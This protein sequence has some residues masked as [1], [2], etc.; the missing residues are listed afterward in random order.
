MIRRSK[1]GRSAKRSFA[2]IAKKWQNARRSLLGGLRRLTDF[3]EQTIS[4]PD[5]AERKQPNSG[6]LVNPLYWL[7][8]GFKFV[9]RYLTSRSA[10][11]AVQGMPALLGIVAPL[12]FGIWLT[13]SESKLLDRARS[14]RD[15]LISQ[16]QHEEADFYARWMCTLRP[17]EPQPLLDRARLLHAMNR[18]D[19]AK[20]I[21]LQLSSDKKFVPAL[22]WLCDL[23]LQTLKDATIP[24]DAKMQ[25]LTAR[26]LFI[27]AK[28]PSS[29]QAQ[30]MLG[31]VYL[32]QNN[33]AQAAV[34]FQEVL[35]L[36]RQPIPEVHYSLA[37]VQQKLGEVAQSRKNAS[38]AAD[39][40]LER[41]ATQPFALQ[42]TVQLLRSL[43]MAERENEAAD[44]VNQLLP[45]R[46]P[47]EQEQLKWLLA[48]VYAQWSKRLRE[49]EKRTAQDL[50]R[51]VN[52]VHQGL[53]A[54]ASN[55][56]ITEE[57]V[58][59][60]CL[61]EIDDAALDQQLEI[62]LNSGVSPG[63]VHFIQGTRSL[64]GDTPDPETAMQHFELA[65]THNAALPG[66]LNN[67]AD[68]MADS[69]EADLDQALK[70]IEQAITSMPNQP[71]F[72]DTRGK[73]KLRQGEPLEAIADFEKALAAPEIRGV[74]HRQL[75]EAFKTLGNDAESRKHAKLATKYR[76]R[77]N[78]SN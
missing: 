57:L 54:S 13:P 41:L 11:A 5:G 76:N 10:L 67:M 58:A 45:K 40:F 63:L 36:T 14:K 38:V 47:Q 37:V 69:D 60:S 21:A 24:D 66:L 43:L 74:V 29:V 7:V 35:R 70:L 73:I 6:S 42:D 49:R 44:F 4:L 33:Y 31:T 46:T 1:M 64:L 77:K 27:I 56:V 39:E 55:P 59:L 17:G 51:A 2:S 18:E 15:F 68:A 34:P 48:E 19:E 28:K 62:A 72:Y 20:A 8:Q 75:A 65:A 9:G 22:E 53:A 26:L 32:M 3:K 30:F 23:D 52:L 71:H 16:D 50:A 25:Q 78:L 12:V 61:S